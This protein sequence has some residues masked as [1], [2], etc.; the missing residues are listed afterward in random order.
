VSSR[1]RES[2]TQNL[3]NRGLFSQT[4]NEARFESSPF[5]SASLAELWEEWRQAEDESGSALDAWYRASKGGKA[6]AYAAYQVAL[7]LEA[8][9]AD[10]LALA[11]DRSSETGAL[12]A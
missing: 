9:A 2:K 6:R 8:L 10:A 4:S 1:K 5:P 12:A 3:R 7:E 11:L